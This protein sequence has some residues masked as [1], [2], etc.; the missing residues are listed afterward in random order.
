MMIRRL[1]SK[2]HQARVTQ[3]DLDFMDSVLIDLAL[4]E[5][6]GLSEGEI[7]QID[8]G[9]SGH[10]FETHVIP[11]ERNSGIVCLNGFSG[12]N[13]KIGDT[14]TISAAIW[15]SSENL[16]PF[17]PFLVFPTEENKLP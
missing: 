5:A 10:R 16:N 7:V 14:I 9:M 17:E 15:E 13:A 3:V 11:G 4:M 2:I 1:K 12:R 6:A 8:Y